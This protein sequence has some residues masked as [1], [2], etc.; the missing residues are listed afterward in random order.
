MVNRQ[1]L[2]VAHALSLIPLFMSG[3]IPRSLKVKLLSPLTSNPRTCTLYFVQAHYT[4][5]GQMLE[6][7]EKSGLLR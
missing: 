6:T 2:G 5:L 4:V 1:G 7:K 3:T